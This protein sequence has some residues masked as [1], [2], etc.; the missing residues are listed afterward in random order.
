MSLAFGPGGHEIRVWDLVSG[1]RRLFRTSPHNKTVTW[2]GFSNGRRRLVS[3]SLDAQIKFHDVATFAT[4]HSIR[5]PSP[6]LSAAVAVSAFSFLFKNVCV[7]K[8]FDDMFS[9][10]NEC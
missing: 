7:V 8:N 6:V 2:L 4:V 1:G 10:L 3:A 5:F 9:M